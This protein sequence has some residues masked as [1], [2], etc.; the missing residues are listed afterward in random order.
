MSNRKRLGVVFYIKT[1]IKLL[2]GPKAFR[3]AKKK[4]YVDAEVVSMTEKFPAFYVTCT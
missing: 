3:H 2:V 1:C 4:K